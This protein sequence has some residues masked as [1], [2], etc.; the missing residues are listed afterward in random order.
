MVCRMISGL[1]LAPAYLRRAFARIGV[2][3]QTFLLL[4]AVLIGVITAAAAVSF[5]ELINAIRDLLYRRLGHGQNLY[6]TRLPLLIALPAMGGLTVGVMSRY[7][8]RIREGHGIIDVMESVIRTKGFI[9]PASAVE[10]I[11]TSAVTIGSGGS[12]GAEG[13]IV[14]IGAAIASGVGSVFRIA[15]PNMPVLIGCGSAAGISAIFNSPI[16]GVLFTLEV[17][18]LDFSLSTITPVIVASVIANVTTQAIFQRMLH[19]HSFAIFQM[20]GPLGQLTL[21]WGQLPNFAVLGAVCGVV[22]VSLTRLMYYTEERFARSR[23]PAALRPAAGGAMLGVMGCVYVVVFGWWILHTPKPFEFDTYPMPAFFG[24]GYGVMLQLF[25]ADFY[26][27]HRLLTLLWLM[28]VLCLAKVIGTCL[29]LGSGGS[30]G[31]IAPSLFLGATAGAALGILLRGAGFFTQ[32]QPHIYA[33]VGMSAV[34]AAVVHAPLASILILLDITGKP[35]LM[36]PAMLASVIATGVA[37]AIFPDS[38]YTWTL[39][40]RGVRVGGAG[41][42]IQLHR[43]NLEQLPLE[44]AATVHA[45]D[46]FQHVLNLLERTGLTDFVVVDKE[47]FYQGMVLA[48]DINAA[49]LQRDAM[50][51]LMIEDLMRTDVPFVKTTDDLASVLDTFARYDVDHLPVCLTGQPGRVIGLVSRIGLLRRYNAN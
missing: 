40:K 21:S 24:D 6:D 15:R 50:A 25:S 26:N 5:H 14:Q 31:I 49:L 39:R 4:L 17:I 35:E 43:S 22:G 30:G 1:S 27:G 34:L 2:R 47:G 20:P 38:I 7:V 28:V 9:H 37:Q 51:M 42:S 23:L 32:V 33:L 10:K 13:P 46:E 45:R 48:P 3:D 44:P 29:T 8:M 41:A 12:A 16:G 36:L 11:L 18:L 19:A